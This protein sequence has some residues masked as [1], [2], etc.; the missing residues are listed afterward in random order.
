MDF[1]KLN[2]LKTSQILKAAGLLVLVVLVLAVLLRLVVSTVNMNGG[3]GSMSQSVS[4]KGMA[5]AMNYDMAMEESA[6]GL[7]LEIL[8]GSRGRDYGRGCGD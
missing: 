5:P 7:L 1:S 2:Q 4:Y 6:Y 8:C 3:Y